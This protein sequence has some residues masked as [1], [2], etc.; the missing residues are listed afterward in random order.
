[1]AEFDHEEGGK[2]GISRRDFLKTGAAAAAVSATGISFAAAP[3][4]AAAAEVADTFHTTCPYCSA[5]C[6]QLVDVDASGNVLDVYGDHMSPFNDGG[7]CAKGA[8]AFQLVTNPR[9]IGAFAGTHPVNNTFA[10][11]SAY[12]DGIAYK[13]IGN[14]A[15]TKVALDTALADIA[16]GMKAARDASGAA[17]SYANG[18]NS[19]QVAFFGSSHLNNEA[20]YFY[21]RLVAQFGTSNVEHQ[22]RI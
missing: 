20:N 9:R 6:G 7:L 14:A 3:S 8:G 21:R 5:S 18:Y 15:W 4:L 12:A 16:T 11:D 1:M 19:K 10:Y 17:P 13:R 22:A 2:Q